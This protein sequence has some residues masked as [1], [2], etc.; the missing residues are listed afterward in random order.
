M[1]ILILSDSHGNLEPA[2]RIIETEQPDRVLHL[3]DLQKDA[4]A[5]KERYPSLRLAYVP[6]NCDGGSDSSCTGVMTVDGCRILYTHGHEHGV[7][8]GLTRLHLA[9]REAGVQIAAF[10]H[11]HQPFCE[12]SDGVWMVNP[13]SCQRSANYALIELTDG[14]PRCSLHCL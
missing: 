4:M 7:K 10:G 13:G 11:T 6:G 5:L 12:Y 1:K 8:W 14:V 2:C 9:A 3:G